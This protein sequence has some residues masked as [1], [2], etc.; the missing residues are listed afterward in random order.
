MSAEELLQKSE[1][2]ALA[3]NQFITNVSGIKQLSKFSG[4][5]KLKAFGAMGFLTAMIVI[6][7]VFFSS[8]NLIP[9]AISERLIEETDVQYAD[10]V[11]SKK[12]VFQ[13]ALRN[14]NIPNNTASNLKS[15]GVL[16]G[17]IDNGEFVESNQSGGEL[18][19]KMGDKIISASDFIKESSENV[20]L[21]N[22]FN[23]STYSRAAYY[24]D[25]PAKDVFKKIGTTRDNYTSETEFD[26]V[27]DSLVGKG[28]NVSINSVS[29]V[30]TET[31]NADGQKEISYTYTEN[32]NNARSGKDTESFVNEVREKNP[33][34]TSTESALGSADTL[35]VADK[36]SKKQRSSLFFLTF[37]ENISKMKAGE[38]N[39]SQI[40]DA[41]N[42]LYKNE[43]SEVVDVKT[44][45]VIQETGTPLESP[46]LYAVLAGSKVDTDAVSNYSSDRV[47]KTVENR[48]G[49]SNSGDIIRGT[50]AS[51]KEKIKGS[52]GRFTNSGNELA[53]SDSL[54]VIKPTIQSSLVDNSYRTIKGIDAGEFLVEGAINVGAELARASGATPGDAESVRQYAKLNSTV[55]AMD[56]K[57]DRLNR[58][59]FDVTS[60][61]TFLGSIIYN[62]AIAVSH[63][64]SGLFSGV[65]TFAETVNTSVVALLPTSHAD[66][67]DNG[68]YLTTFGDCETLATIGAVGT[69]QCADSAT[70]DTSTLNDTFNDPGFIEFV[71][72]NTTLSSS[73]N[74]TINSDS[75]LARFIRDNDERVT[76][77]GVVDGGILESESNNSGSVSFISN[78][79][80]MVKKFLESDDNSKR[81]ASGEAFVNSYS[82]SDWSTYKYAQRYVSL[83]RATAVLRQYADDKTAYTT[84]PFFE[85]EENPV[86]AYLRDYYAYNND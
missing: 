12:L 76:P 17:Y 26:D 73:G 68:R 25:E 81:L 22:A 36:I 11:E 53:S 54:D 63:N 5:K 6:F 80:G 3:N 61:N 77:I 67:D 27:M 39:E 72:N 15:R 55:L 86:I 2:N 44:G 1:D 10:A 23:E 71:N 29:M 62:L 9:S 51:T 40:N 37:M 66:D 74:R 84:I 50:V 45:G 60:K 43:E 78:I 16:V 38:G 20:Q 47:L 35:K 65:N 19:L 57:A 18:V 56:A 8:G 4:G 75:V 64:K 41:M 70:F 52:I 7:G 34:A 46:S 59:P 13:Q 32:G 85:G 33:G 24:Y 31:T 79:L 58:S 82:N 30:E 69:A 49:N 42:Y 48:V 21:Y 28:S 14:G 83:A